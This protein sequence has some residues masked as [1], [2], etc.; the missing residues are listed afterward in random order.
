MAT[1]LDE[2]LGRLNG[3]FALMQQATGLFAAAETE[4][5]AGRIEEAVATR[6]QLVDVLEREIEQIGEHDRLFPES[7]F[8][9]E[10]AVDQLLDAALVRAD[11]LDALG[12]RDEAEVVRERAMARSAGRAAPNVAERKRQRAASLLS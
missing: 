4:R 8:G 5:S 3:I 11:L 7:P 9:A 12:R 2:K 6:A 1:A 10:A